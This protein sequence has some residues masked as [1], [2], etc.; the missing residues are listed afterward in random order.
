MSC[1]TRHTQLSAA[2]LERRIVELEQDL[3]SRDE[4]VAEQKLE[5]ARLQ[6]ERDEL[7]SI[8][9]Q[10]HEEM[11]EREAEHR[12]VVDEDRKSVV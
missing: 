12:E 4:V 7:A 3:E 2:S 11:G 6:A 9:E 1:L 8:R 10:L 5:I